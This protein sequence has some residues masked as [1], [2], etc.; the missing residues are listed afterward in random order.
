VEWSEAERLEDQHVERALDDV[1]VRLVH[2]ARSERLRIGRFDRTATL[3][4]YILI[5][6]M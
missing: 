4:A 5:V 6:K 3:P 2:V 1:G